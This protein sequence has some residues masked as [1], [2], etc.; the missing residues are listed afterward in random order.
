LGLPGAV[1]GVA[2]A[3][4]LGQLLRRFLFGVTTTDPW[5]F[6][7]AVTLVLATAALAAYLPARR[8]ARADLAAQLR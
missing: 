5:S 4:A 2:M 3:A 6:A 7:A 8:V 1:A